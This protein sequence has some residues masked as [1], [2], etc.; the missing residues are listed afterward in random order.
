MLLDDLPQKPRERCSN[1][2]QNPEQRREDE[3]SHGNGFKRNRHRMGLVQVKLNF[4]D[5]GDQFD[6]V[7]DYGCE[8]KCDDR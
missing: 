2:D 3:A 1:R 5:M 7:N 8:Q 4:A 6:P